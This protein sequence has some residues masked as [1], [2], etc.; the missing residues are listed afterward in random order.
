MVDNGLKLK[1]LNSNVSYYY[2][3]FEEIKLR[4]AVKEEQW[5]IVTKVIN[6]LRDDLKGEVILHHPESLAQA[7]QKALEIE[8]YKKPSYSRRWASSAEE[9]K[10][11]KAVTFQENSYS[12]EQAQSNHFTIN[13]TQLPTSFGKVCHKCHVRGHPPSHCSHRALKITLGRDELI[14]DT[15]YPAVGDTTIKSEHEDDKRDNHL[16]FMRCL[17][18]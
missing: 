16:S 9:S 7:Y 15:I 10:P 3:Q 17:P 14:N 18:S 11:F 1:Q 12:K 8:K 5:V 2:A 6:V 4:C 13:N